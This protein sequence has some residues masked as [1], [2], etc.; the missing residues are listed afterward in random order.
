MEK[1]TRQIPCGLLSGKTYG[2]IERYLG[3]RYAN[4]GRFEYPKQV[5]H[6]DGE[7]E[8]YEYGPAPIQESTYH[9][10]DPEDPKNHY[11]HEFMRGVDPKYSED[12]LFL[13]IWTP[14]NAKKA[15]VL[16]VI[17][18]GGLETGM[19]QELE[20][21]GDEFAR[22]GIITV[23][24]NYRVNVFGFM[25]LKELESE[26]GKA[27]NFGY[28][29]Q[30]MAIEWVRKN[31][32]A[33]GGD[34]NNMTII[35]QSAGAASAEAQIKTPLNKGY[36]RQAIIQS[37]A[38][39]TTVLKAKDNK[40]S[41]DKKWR[42]VYE[43]TGVHSIEELKKM[44]AE[45]LFRIYKE[46]SAKQPIAFCNCVYDDNYGNK[47]KNK[48]VDTKV[49]YSITS[50]DVMPFILHVMG[51]GLSKSQAERTDTYAYY[52]CRRLPG[53]DKGAWHS[54]DLMYVYSTLDKSWRP[55]TEEDYE[56]SKRMIDYFEAFIKTGDPNHEGD[57][58][59]APHNRSGKY[60]FFDVKEKGMKKIPVLHLIK[61]TL[62]G[63]HIGM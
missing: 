37:S 39:F 59:W 50:E 16:I 25:Y 21:N 53:D 55:F 22:R 12:C 18:G 3:I 6:W 58:T 48:A 24:L 26:K 49:M 8:A 2:G 46:I 40:E 34:T 54:S 10:A 5:T 7:Y 14:A 30:Q 42:T 27:G 9:P 28:Y 19:S 61:E 20:F 1:I 32:E 62:L 51:K 57:E 23:T 63:N 29:D 56:L 47:T 41:E 43:K 15:P 35:G 33:L 38:G 52:F 11:P 60:M 44:N 36:F 45:D 17:Y 4:A 13:N 31:I